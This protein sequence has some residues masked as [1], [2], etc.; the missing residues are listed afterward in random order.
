MV[1]LAMVTDGAKVGEYWVVG[2]IVDVESV[3]DWYYISC[4]S[5]CCK[6]KVTEC[7]GMMYCG[8]GKASWHEKVV[9][10]KVIVRVADDSGDA[11]ML[12]WDRSDLEVVLPPRPITG[13]TEMVLDECGETTLHDV[14]IEE[15]MRRKQQQQ[16][17]EAYEEDNDM[18]GGAQRVQYA[19][20]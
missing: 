19:Q 13:I 3:I 12:L 17:Q 6:R 1:A 10:Y 15:D 11:P 18:H 5:N 14:N 4:K 2:T 7:G 8:G 16:A 20:Q 9:R